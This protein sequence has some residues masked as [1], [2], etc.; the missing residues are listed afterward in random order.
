MRLP[1]CPGPTRRPRPPLRPAPRRRRGHRRRPDHRRAGHRRR[2]GQG[3]GDQEGLPRA[4][5]PTP[6]PPTGTTCR[7]RCRRASTRST[8]SYDYEPTD[9]GIGISYN[10]VD[11]G[12]FDASGHGLGNAE[13]F[14]GWS[15]GARREFTIKTGRAT[16][17]YI[18]GPLTPGRWHILLGPYLINPPGTP[19]KVVVSMHLGPKGEEFQPEPGAAGGRRH[20]T[21]LVPRRPAPP[22]RPLRRQAQ[23]APAARRPR[24]RRAWTSSAPPTTTPAPRRTSGAGT[25]P[26]T[27]WSSTA[28]RSRPAAATGWRWGCPR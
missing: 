24:A 14:R 21:R 2:Q 19:Y 9:T 6:P 23:P 11:I 26:T 27:S 17:G 20:R 8:S 25:C 5:S 13:G 10:V 7:S 16:P 18:A 1:P 28:R 12:I 4:S 15:G 22:H 3:Q